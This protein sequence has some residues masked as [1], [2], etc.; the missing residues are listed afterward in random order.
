VPWTESDTAKMDE[1]ALSAAT[2]LDAA[3]KANPK[4]AEGAY[5]LM[6]WLEK[7]YKSA[8]YKRLCRHLLALLKAQPAHK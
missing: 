2:E 6:G 5:F 1:A 4:I 3:L 8:G 7:W